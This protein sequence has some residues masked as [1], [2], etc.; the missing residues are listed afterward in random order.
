MV[1]R[2]IPVADTVFD[3]TE[4]E[5]VSRAIAD[6]AVSGS[7]G[8]FIQQFENEFSA[9]VGCKYGVAVSNGTN[10]IHLALAAL[11]IGAGDEVLVATYT[12]MATFFAVLYV[13]ATPIPI[14][15]ELDT[16]NIDPR[17]VEQHLTKRT[18]AIIVVHVFGH[19]VDMD[20]IM[21]IARRHNLFVIEDCAEAHG[22]LYKNQ[23]VGSIG[24]V[25]CFSFYANKIITTGEGGM[26]TTNDRNL[27]KRAAS[28]KSLAYGATDRFMHE[29][30]GY[31]YRMTN[32]QAALGCA[33]M[34]KLSH[35]IDG[36]RRLADS[37]NRLLSGIR[38]LYLPVEKSY[39]KNVYWMYHVVLTEHCLKR[40]DE[41]MGQLKTRGIETRPGFVPYNMQNIFIEKG[42]TKP[43][44]CPVASRLASDAFYLPSTPTMPESDIT[45]VASNLLE[46]LKV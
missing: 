16:W 2:H 5:Y 15:V 13:G 28:L 44:D 25:G 19:P 7:F 33:Q 17:L 23:P 34:R 3:G 14:D 42:M 43:D 39:A 29:S 10:A 40:R 38:S 41:V 1:D 6:K 37:Y 4:I 46:V 8:S 11:G 27:A 18:R 30:V 31:N 20:P 9:F 45:Y 36:K 21:E 26:L 22:A 35:L 32:L 24:I 12:N